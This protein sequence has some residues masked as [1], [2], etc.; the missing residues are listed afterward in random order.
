MQEPFSPPHKRVDYAL[1]HK[2]CGLRVTNGTLNV[3][4]SVPV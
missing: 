3:D 1:D 2:C 4:A